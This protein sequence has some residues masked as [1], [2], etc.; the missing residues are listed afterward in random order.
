MVAWPAAGIAASWPRAPL[1]GK[2]RAQFRRYPSRAHA[3][4][5]TFPPAH[6]G[7]APGISLR[8]SRPVQYAMNTVR[9]PLP[10]VL[11]AVLL[12]AA[13]VL[14]QSEAE[15]KSHERMVK[16]LREIAE[17]AKIDHHYHGTGEAKAFWAELAA[18]G[19]KAPWKL[20]L[21]AALAHLRLGTTHEGITI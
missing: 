12:A 14:A 2:V 7:A 17:R 18:Q 11:L 20:R 16:T 15:A 21:D 9:R 8:P 10:R 3:G 6:S 19:D 13:P 1:L 4:L 5:R